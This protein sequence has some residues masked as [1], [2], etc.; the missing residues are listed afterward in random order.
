MALLSEIGQP[1]FVEVIRVDP[2]TGTTCESKAILGNS[3]WQNP[4]DR[5]DVNGD[6]TVDDIDYNV[7]LQWIGQHGQGSLAGLKPDADPWVDVNGDGI[8]DDKDLQ[9]LSDYLAGRRDESDPTCHQVSDFTIERDLLDPAQIIDCTT[10]PTVRAVACHKNVIP[11]AD[12]TPYF[13]VYTGFLETTWSAVVKTKDSVVFVHNDLLVPRDEYFAGCS[14]TPRVLNRILRRLQAQSLPHRYDPRYPLP[15]WPDDVSEWRPGDAP[16]PTP[17][18]DEPILPTEPGVATTTTTTPEPAPGILERVVILNIFGNAHWYLNTE[19]WYAGSRHRQATGSAYGDTLWDL[20]FQASGSH[21]E[22]DRTLWNLFV[23]SISANDSIS[24][25]VGLVHPEGTGELWPSGED[26]PKDSYRT[27]V[28]YISFEQKSP[29]LSANNII[30]AF[31]MVTQNGQFAPTLLIFVTD[32]A[33]DSVWASQIA[34]AASRLSNEYP[35]M[36][37]LKY[38]FSKPFSRWIMMDL[39]AMFQ[40]VYQH[41]NINNTDISSSYRINGVEGVIEDPAAFQQLRRTH[42]EIRL[43]NN[44]ARVNWY[45]IPFEPN[46]PGGIYGGASGGVYRGKADGCYAVLNPFGW[47]I[48]SQLA[49]ADTLGSRPQ[50]TPVNFTSNPYFIYQQ[51]DSEHGLFSLNYIWTD[52][53]VIPT[54]RVV[55]PSSNGSVGL[56]THVAYAHDTVKI[57]QSSWLG[58]YMGGMEQNIRIDAYASANISDTTSVVL[59][60]AQG[61]DR[62]SANYCPR[63]APQLKYQSP[64]NVVDVF[65][66]THLDPSYGRLT[67]AEGGYYISIWY[68][69]LHAVVTE[70]R[71]TGP[72][73]KDHFVPVNNLE[74]RQRAI[75][76]YS[77]PDFQD[78]I[79]DVAKYFYEANSR[80]T[81][82]DTDP[83]RPFNA[84]SWN[85]YTQLRLSLNARYPWELA[86]GCGPSGPGDECIQPSTNQSGFPLLQPTAFVMQCPGLPVRVR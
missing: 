54:I 49:V 74:E 84:R 34:R 33:E 39:D 20:G 27:Q 53:I 83:D 8:V 38:P 9:Q 6:G 30:N 52:A 16:E 68:N 23:D 62:C 85:Y 50:R 71:I 35:R 61:I 57:G 58:P 14:D 12:Y 3:R 26:L 28:D 76:V 75:V 73:T 15:S 7:L 32:Q 2:Y 37:I 77:D 36:E 31:N 79:Y 25:R 41:D 5:F 45:E 69:D 51:D 17:I 81:T 64:T 66:V 21:Y 11:T 63:W 10:D 29:R 59:S 82:L 86:Q 72:R 47:T 43:V 42:I 40:L 70:G 19:D 18:P 44:A 24:V 1:T 80:Y 46:T 22:D 78:K 4:Y 13:Y 67:A 48:D 55:D 56:R 60:R 65:P